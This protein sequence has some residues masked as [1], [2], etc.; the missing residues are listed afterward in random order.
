VAFLVVYALATEALALAETKT[1]TDAAYG[2]LINALSGAPT[3]DAPNWGARVAVV[4]LTLTS[5]GVIPAITAT[6]VDALVKLQ[7]QREAGGLYDPISGH[8]VVIG[9]GDLGTRIVQAL[10]NQGVEVVAIERDA[11]TPGVQVARDLKIPVIIGEGS[12]AE[13]L[14][15]ASTRTAAALVVA[16]SDDVSNLE[17]AL[18][19]LAAQPE[20]RVVV[21]LF[22][23]EFADRVRRS[24]AI[25]I[26][27]SVS[28]LAAPAFAAAMFGRAVLATIPVRRRVMLVAEVPVGE[29][30]LIELRP[31][32]FVNR[33][34]ES[35]L[36]AVRTSD[37]VVWRPSEGRPL[38]RGDRLIVVATRAGLSR[39]LAESH[40]GTDTAPDE[41]FRLLAPWE[42]P[43]ARSAVDAPAS[44]TSE[45][46][47]AIPP[48][49]PA[50]AGST[51]PA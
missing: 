25:Q 37:Q 41:P 38:R 39:L 27:R 36:L 6:V 8:T 16:S 40:T 28:Y 13:T 2:A 22:D 30:S 51:R 18:L 50:D 12:R 49:G 24:F 43:Q 10:R 7:L 47:A 21:R 19:G 20:L 11:S 45:G 31:V 15:R 35:R 14:D 17:I 4:V 44:A 29:H 34:H 42:L 5:L 32:A 46:T 26:S 1:W 23:A 3:S 9:L 48:I 33:P